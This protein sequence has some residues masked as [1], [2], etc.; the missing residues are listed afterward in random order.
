MDIDK[1]IDILNDA[2]SYGLKTVT[3]LHVDSE[4]DYH[5]T[6]SDVIGYTYYNKENKLILH[7]QYL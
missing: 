4:D 3:I 1:F 2:K 5:F 6:A 7:P